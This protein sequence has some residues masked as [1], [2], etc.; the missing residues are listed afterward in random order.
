[1]R[2]WSDSSRIARAM[3]WPWRGPSI[4]VRRIR[5]SSVPC[6]WAAYSRSARFRIDI[7]P[8]YPYASGG[9][10][11]RKRPP[12]D[13]DREIQAHLE[14]EADHLQGQGL[15]PEAAHAAAR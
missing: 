10:S 7:R 5:R 13:F 6:R 15:A 12:E 4:R 3:P 14:L 11:T 8:E 1:M 9:M 2:T